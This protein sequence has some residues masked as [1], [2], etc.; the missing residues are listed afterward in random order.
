MEDEHFAKLLSQ[1]A[2]LIEHELPHKLLETLEQREIGREECFEALLAHYRARPLRTVRNSELEHPRGRAS[3]DQWVCR[4]AEDPP[5]FLC[6]GPGLVNLGQVETCQAV[7]R[8]QIPSDRFTDREMVVADLQVADSTAKV[9]GG[10]LARREVKVG[11]FETGSAWTDLCLDFLYEKTLRLDFKIDWKGQVPL[12]FREVLVQERVDRK[13]DF[14]DRKLDHSIFRSPSGRKVSLSAVHQAHLSNSLFVTSHRSALSEAAENSQLTVLLM[15]T[16]SSEWRFLRLLLQKRLKLLT[17]E[18]VFP[19]V[20]SDPV[21]VGLK[22]SLINQVLSWGTQLRDVR[23]AICGCDQ[24]WPAVVVAKIGVL[25][26]FSTA[27]AGSGHQHTMLLNAE[28]PFTQRILNLAETDDVMAAYLLCRQFLLQIGS[29]ERVDSR[30]ALQA[31]RQAK[32]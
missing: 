4:P 25:Q 11:D 32:K 6:K 28:N 12:F 19:Q 13:L 14:Q 9:E 1:V 10:L 20:L 17:E 29:T 8:L 31:W 23:L 26:P 22:Q 16:Q 18:F 2:D 24:S 15:H 27:I 5:G 3:G 21:P 7:F 30:L